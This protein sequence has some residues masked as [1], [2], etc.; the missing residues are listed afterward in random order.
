MPPWLARV[1]GIF[2]SRKKILMYIAG[3][4][5]T[6]ISLVFGVSPSE[7]K[8]A[9]KDAQAIEIP[10]VDAAAADQNGSGK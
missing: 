7:V 9:V 4:V 2:F 10:S 1:A 8:E 5:L 3:I 6:V